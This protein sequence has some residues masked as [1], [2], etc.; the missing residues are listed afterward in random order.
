MSRLHP[1]VLF[2]LLLTLP[3]LACNL[4]G[5][6][7][8]TPTPLPTAAPAVVRTETPVP[9]RAEP[10][11][12]EQPLLE[13]T[14]TEQPPEATAT[15]RASKP[16][17]A[18]SPTTAIDA[19]VPSLAQERYVHPGEYFSLLPPAGWEVSEDEA[20]A[21]FEATDGSGFIYLQVTNTGY[22][23][24]AAAF[25][26]FVENRDLN[27]FRDFAD[28][29]VV[30]MSVDEETRVGTVSK[31]LSFEGTP[32]TVVSVY[33]QYGP[34]IYT[35][36]FWTE[37][38]YMD[39]YSDL[40]TTVLENAEVNP[41]AASELLEYYWIYTFSGPGNLFSIEVPTPWAYETSEDDVSI[42]D[43]FYAPDGHAVIQNI[44]YDEGEPISRSDA[45]QFALALLREFYAE[46]INIS[47]DQVQADGSERLTWQSQSGDYSGISFL[48][49]RG[50]T[51]LLFTVMWDKPYEDVY[52]DTL[53]Y[54]VGSYTV[55]E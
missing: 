21:S 43:T 31:S 42:I 15:Q 39:A 35:Y 19:E 36:D 10:T 5:G 47:N 11:A 2:L 51:F 20:S 54:T 34:I 28:Y 38:G 4:A 49:T 30:D 12:T 9:L 16:T 55:P 26:S 24:D 45:G 13:A 29:E 22:E 25:S 48:E 8:A 50:T 53:D 3:A 32:H 40:Y 33:D 1:L 37:E 46:D 14:A 27:Y 23:L 7:E 17:A 52:F 6:E 44:T 18:P 41:E